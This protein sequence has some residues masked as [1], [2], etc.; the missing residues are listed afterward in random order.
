MI[1]TKGAR[2]LWLIRRPEDFRDYKSGMCGDWVFSFKVLQVDEI[3]NTAWRDVSNIALGDLIVS[4]HIF[5]RNDPSAPA[6]VPLDGC[7]Y[8]DD[9]YLPAM[10]SA[11]APRLDGRPRYSCDIGHKA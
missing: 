3:D 7:S 6:R 8:V 9:S 1:A 2:L 4:C 10:Q 11:P 5:F